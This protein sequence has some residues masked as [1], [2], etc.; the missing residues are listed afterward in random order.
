MSF[1]LALIERIRLSSVVFARNGRRIAVLAAAGIAALAAPAGAVGT[2]TVSPSTLTFPD[3]S[4][5]LSP[6]VDAAQNP[7]QVNI[8]SSRR[9]TWTLSVM[10]NSDFISGADSIPV[11]N[12]SWSATGS[13]FLPTGTMSQSA[14]QTV[15]TGSQGIFSGTLS[16]HLRNLWTYPTGSYSTTIVYLLVTP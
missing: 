1:I 11:Q 4:P 15:A 9:G 2:L 5:S 8:A 13:T 14:A 3:A 10:A 7:V 16:Y 6:S 12:M